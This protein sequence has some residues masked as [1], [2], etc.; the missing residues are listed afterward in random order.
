MNALTTMNK[1]ALARQQSDAREAEKG[2]AC[3]RI[4][5]GIFNYNSVPRDTDPGNSSSMKQD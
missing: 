2:T 5:F 1:E 4:N 3:H